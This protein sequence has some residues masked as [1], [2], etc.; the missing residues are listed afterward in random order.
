MLLVGVIALVVAGCS[1]DDNDTAT[2]GAD[3]SPTNVQVAK[4]EAIAAL[5][6]ENVRSSGELKV[7]VNVPYSPNEFKDS[8]GNI[9]G[10]DVDLMN[11]VTKVL[12]LKPQYIEAQFDKIIPSI[13]AGTYDVGMS[14]FTVN[15]ERLQQVD[16]VSY[17]SAGI[18]WAQRT[19][20]A[21]DPNNACGKKVAVQSHTV[22]ADTELPAKSKACTD[23]GKDA[24][25]IV[26]FD[27]QDQATN[28]L[29]LSKVDVM[30]ADSPVTA[31]AIARSNGKL[32]L[33][34]GVA[35]SEPYGW[36]VQKGSSLGPAMQKAL[37]YLIDNGQYKAIAEHWTVQAGMIQTPVINPPVS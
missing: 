28:A 32:A 11:A 15:P 21:I 20:E 8:S 33:A 10:F 26:K 31:Y 14:S 22:E 18:Q 25:E 5:L 17:F 29:L 34:G 3:I 9:I 4:N 30:S 23:A 1:N 36:A 12:G 27:S 24:I 7:G 19:G 16:F 6:P 2:L 13:V 37:Q 35:E